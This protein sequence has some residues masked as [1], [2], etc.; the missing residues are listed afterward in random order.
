MPVTKWTMPLTVTTPLPVP[1]PVAAIMM[2]A[3][4]RSLGGAGSAP[5]PAAG[6]GPAAAR[7][8]PDRARWHRVTAVATGNLKGPWEG[9][10]VHWQTSSRGPSHAAGAGGG[11]LPST[12]GP[13]PLQ[14]ELEATGPQEHWHF[15]KLAKGPGLG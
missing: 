8:G 5:P 12:G 6:P 14:V 10:P 13:S 4:A 1:V 9:G 3:Q 7:A 2:P 15:E 11:T